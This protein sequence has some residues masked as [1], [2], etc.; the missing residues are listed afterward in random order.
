MIHNIFDVLLVLVFLK[1]VIGIRFPWE[2]VSKLK[3]QILSELKEVKDDIGEE[4]YHS[5]NEKLTEL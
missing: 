5:I 4:A 2:H 1:A 3:K